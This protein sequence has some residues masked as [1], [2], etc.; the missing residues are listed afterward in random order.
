MRGSISTREVKTKNL[1]RKISSHTSSALN[2]INNS[3]SIEDSET[4]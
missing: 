4:P 1:P 3:M 2:S